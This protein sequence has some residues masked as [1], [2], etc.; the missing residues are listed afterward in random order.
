MNTMMDVGN[1]RVTFGGQTQKRQTIPVS[2]HGCGFTVPVSHHRAVPASDP[3]PA[4]SLKN[5]LGFWELVFGNAT[6]IL[7]QHQALFY[8]A[9]LLARPGA[10]PISAAELDSAVHQLF[11]EHEDFAQTPPTFW[12]KGDRAH[13]LKL[14]RRREQALCNLLDS[15]DALDPVKNEALQELAEVQ[16][17]QEKQFDELIQSSCD[18]GVSIGK[19]MLKLCNALM[20]AV[21]VRGHPHP[22]IRGFARH[23]LLRLIM[24][25]ERASR[26]LGQAHFTYQPHVD[27]NS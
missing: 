24:P 15:A 27:L 19:A 10:E 26:A 13:V 20:T 12:L 22:T 17:Q 8:V 18:V 1:R 21:D 11:S 3:E 14:L 2:F 4:V 16:Q 6:A 5:E 7:P 23:L 9:F 25:S